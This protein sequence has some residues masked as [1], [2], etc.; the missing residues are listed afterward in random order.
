[1]YIAPAAL[2]QLQT[3]HQHGQ[4]ETNGNGA[5]PVLSVRNI[6]SFTTC[7]G[8]GHFAK[9]GVIWHSGWGVVKDIENDTALGLGKVAIGLRGKRAVMSSH[10]GKKR[11]CLS[12]KCKGERTHTHIH[13]HRRCTPL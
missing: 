12:P 10:G 13:T 3:H 8:G 7:R 11:H 6:C 2:T 4:N 5:V 1:M 9:V